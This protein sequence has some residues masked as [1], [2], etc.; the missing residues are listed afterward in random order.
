MVANAV[1]ERMSTSAVA[2]A[3]GYSVQQ[4]RDLEA[5]GV[6]PAAVRSANGYRRF[7]VEH[8]CGLNAYRDLAVAVGPVEARRALRDVRSCPPDEA[9][10]LIGGFHT[11]LNAERAHV[12]WARSAL[13]SI[14][15]EV[16]T[17]AAPIE[18]DSMTISELAQALGVRPS[19]LRFW[20]S[21]GLVTP[22]RV[23]TRSGTAR[24]YPV[25]AIREARITAAL[26]A[27]G[28]RIPDVQ[29]A[30]TALRDLHDPSDSLVALDARIQSI[31]QRQLALLR[32]GSLVAEIIE[33]TYEARLPSGM[34]QS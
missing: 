24:S 22:E 17:D 29:K 4:V 15:S 20:E 25:A 19:T 12:L 23:V 30:M 6:I 3:T 34:E 32:A 14:S 33:K 10:A 9:A 18:A 5:E 27:G 21:C 11:R 31:A 2:A 16:A 13:E 7:S 8:V 1:A 26:R 28:Y